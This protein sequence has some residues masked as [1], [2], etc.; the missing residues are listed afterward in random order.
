MG[1]QFDTNEKSYITISNVVCL[2]TFLVT[3][4]AHVFYIIST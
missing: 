4:T 2:T 1:I 3:E